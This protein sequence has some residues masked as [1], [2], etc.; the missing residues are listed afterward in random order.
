[1]QPL[2]LLIKPCGSDCNIDCRC[3]SYKDRDARFGHGVHMQIAAAVEKGQQTQR[4]RP[5]QRGC[6]HIE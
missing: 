5:A 2:T 4:T 6:L 1:M 3:F